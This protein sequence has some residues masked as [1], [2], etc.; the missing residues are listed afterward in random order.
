V[1]AISSVAGVD[2][3]SHPAA[4]GAIQRRG[5]EA[6][7]NTPKSENVKLLLER[8]NILER[9]IY[10]MQDQDQDQEDRKMSQ[11][12]DD[13]CGAV[14]VEAEERDRFSA[15]MRGMF[16]GRDVEDVPRFRSLHQSWRVMTRTT[17]G[18][19]EVAR[20]MY[21]AA[22]KSLCTEHHPGGQ[23]EYNKQ[24]RFSAASLAVSDW[25][26]AFGDSVTRRLVDRFQAEVDDVRALASFTKQVRDFRTQN[27]VIIG[28]LGDLDTVGEGTTY[29][30]VTPP[31][32]TQATYAVSKRGNL[33]SINWEAFV[34]DDIGAIRRVPDAMKKAAV[35]TFRKFILNDLIAKNS[36][37]YDSTALF[38][39]GHGN[40]QT[41][42]LA[43][44]ALD[45][46]IQDM[47]T[48]TERDSGEAA[49]YMPKFLVHPSVLRKMAWD[50]TVNELDPSDVSATLM[51]RFRTLY[52]IVPVWNDVQVVDT[53]GAGD[54]TKNW[55]LVADPTKHETLEI[56]FLESEDPQIFIANSE[57][58]GSMFTADQISLKVRHI[59]SGAILDYR[60]FQ[61]NLVA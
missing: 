6:K 5:A 23:V 53:A 8:L 52:G 15:A 61:G 21:T 38:T 50:L 14:T 7:S 28:G 34:N 49:A 1:T 27:A 47:E 2:V 11:Q 54:A 58:E 30:E 32:D 44:A 31:T 3:V 55:F 4:G 24:R 17:A 37:I 18:E 19:G 22:A 42:A 43:A 36:N 9:R 57:T 26:E 25:A 40:L 60:A 33:Y 48:Q 10:T 20:G 59:Y 12:D 51:S 45:T 13:I 29:Q 39:S 56:G 41:T 46:A 35:R 16:E